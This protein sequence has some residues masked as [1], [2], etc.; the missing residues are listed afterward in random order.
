AQAEPLQT[1]LVQSAP[2]RHAWPSPQ[3]GQVLPPQST[4]LSV[5]FLTPSPQV[6][7]ARTDELH[8]R[9][10]QTPATAQ[11]FPLA[12]LVGQEAPQSTSPSVPFW[13]PSLQVGA[14]QIAPMQIR[15][16]QSSPR[17]QRRPVPQVEQVPP[18]STS[19]SAPFRTPSPQPAIPRS[20]DLPPR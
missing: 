7:A 19:V 2:A 18:Q 17:R 3:S 8:T 15:L 6:G 12:H 10:W 14:A 4:S 1:P 11:F 5:P 9:P 20:G 13:I 16:W